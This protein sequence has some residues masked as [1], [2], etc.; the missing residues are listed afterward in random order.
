MKSLYVFLILALAALLLSGCGQESLVPPAQVDLLPETAEVL[1]PE[2]GDEVDLEEVPKRDLGLIWSE[3]YDDVFTTSLSRDGSVIVASGNLGPRWNSRIGFNV[4]D[5]EGNL[6]WQY[7][8]RD[9]GYRGVWTQVLGQGRYVAAASYYYDS[10][11]HVHLFDESGTR[12]WSVPVEGPVTVVM[13]PEG[14]YLAIIDHVA[15]ALMVYDTAGNRL[16]RT[17][18]GEDAQMDIVIGGQLILLKDHRQVALL[19]PQGMRIWSYPLEGTIKRNIALSHSGD[20]VAVAT[21]D[22]DS[23]LYVFDRSGELL[24]KYVLFPSGTNELAFSADDRYLAV[25]NV[26]RRGGIYVFDVESGE[27]LWRRFFRTPSGHVS[28]IRDVVFFLAEEDYLLLVDHVDIFEVD[29]E[30]VEEHRLLAFDE[31]GRPLWWTPLGVNVEVDL[32]R[33]ATTCV[34]S[35]SPAVDGAGRLACELKVFDLAEVLR[36]TL[37]PGPGSIER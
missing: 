30:P 8:F 20:L 3:T 27:L 10:S 12:L 17:E 1:G 25:Y 28:D 5:R 4:Y 13:P 36:G 34:V 2:A 14:D 18:V 22:A 9:R 29:G 23:V 15:S 37:T 33:D 7:R 21:G 32:S 35:T 6:L 19:T 16:V 26:G 24:W 31:A 11:G